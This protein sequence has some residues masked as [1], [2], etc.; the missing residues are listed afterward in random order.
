MVEY[1][2]KTFYLGQYQT[3]KSKFCHKPVSRG[4]KNTI[5]IAT[6]YKVNEKDIKKIDSEYVVLSFQRL[7][8]KGKIK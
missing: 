5:L 2:N 3:N 4:G 1:K 7:V 6:S 8:I